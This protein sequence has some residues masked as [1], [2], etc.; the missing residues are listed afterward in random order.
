MLPSRRTQ[1]DSLVQPLVAQ[2]L[3]MGCQSK[4]NSQNESVSSEEKGKDDARATPRCG[5]RA[6]LSPP[7][8]PHRFHKQGPAHTYHTGKSM[9][10]LGHLT[11]GA[12]WEELIQACL[13]SFDSDGCLCGSGHL[14]NITLTMH[15]LLVSSSDLLDKL[16]T[17]FKT[18][19]DNE[20]PTEC[21]RIC[22][23]IRHWIQEFWMMFRLDRSLSD[24]LDQFRELIREQGQE[25]LCSFLETKWIN[26]RD[27]SWKASQKIKANSSKKRKVSLLFDHLE[28]IEL[29]EHLTYL[30]FK[31][32]CRISFVDYQNYIRN[33]CMKDIPV[34]ER[35]IALC[36]G[37]SQWVQLMVLSR[38][39]AQLRAEVF[40]KFIHVA[41][42]LHLMH[43]YNTLMAVVGGLCH[44]SISRLKDTT[45]HV[46]SEVTKVLNE[47]TD[48][49]SSC[50]NYDNYR[51]AYNRCTGFKIPILGV[52]LKD[53]ISVNEAMSDYV[54]DNKV[55]VQKLQA[56]Y[57]HINELI[58][59]QQ[60]PPRL[61]ANKDLVHLLTLSLDLYYTEDE[62]YEL[63]YA[64]EPK[65]C[66]APPATPS[67]PPVVVDWASG[68]APKP[69]PRTISKHV[70]RM[71]DSVFKN[72]DHDENGFISQ[73]DFEKIAA[74]FPFSFCVMDKEKEGLVSREE[75]TAYFMRA[76][77]ICSKLGLGFVHNFQ[78]TTYMKPT[79]CDNCSGFLWGVIKQGY[80]CKDCGMNCHK[81][82]KDQVAFECK[83]N[84]KVA[85][86]S[87]TPSSTPVT[88][89]TSEGLEECPFPYPP[90]DSKDWSP[91][92]PVTSR[93][94]PQRV[95]SGTQTEG[96]HLSSAALE[97]GRLQPSLLVPTTPTLTS[98]PSPVP[99]RKQ[100]HCAKWENR[101]SVV[102]KPKEPEEESKPSYESLESDNQRL[103]RANETLRRKLRETEREVEILKT[104]LKRHALHPV[105]EDS[106]S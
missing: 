8:R 90:D 64:R 103:Q 17:L 27:W 26:E 95:H 68:V 93:L 105:E 37:I 23:L 59:L 21:Q 72:Y 43:N 74:S 22:Y 94:R 36:N 97:A 87:P 2:Y 106:S 60:I 100:R 57:T 41:Q 16:V 35:S 31:S 76:S 18:A 61:D 70:Q 85:T 52:H 92:S 51:Q 47:M 88:M 91:D 3:A 69:D 96:P 81:L 11:K 77:V 13:Q 82:C 42:S 63:S 46:P 6:R 104:L 29:A 14:L 79:F 30:E 24:S 32:F 66:K 39:T 49:L 44:S 38:P 15:R 99:Q 80:R 55:N 33:C 53:L 19:L 75:I 78:E 54:E 34:M 73:E 50:R 1:M 5:S 28:P 4:E 65:N 67:R 101:A 83:K 56:L 62:I 102:Q 58:Q 10:S 71:V 89:G 9:M 12:S 25:R 84:T 98:C 48:L 40:T 45:S 20:Q 86:D 7:G